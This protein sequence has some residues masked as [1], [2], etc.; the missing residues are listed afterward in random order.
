VE[1]KEEKRRRDKLPLMHWP[2]KR[3][4]IIAQLNRSF[5]YQKGGEKKRKRIMVPLAPKKM[6]NILLH[7]AINYCHY[8]EMR[9]REKKEKGERKRAKILLRIY[10]FAPRK[11]DLRGKKHRRLTRS[12]SIFSDRWRER[13]KSGRGNILAATIPL[14]R[15]GG[16][17][18][19]IVHL[20]YFAA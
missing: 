4:K 8:L 5:T 19:E 13:K 1:G 6:E 12:R 7:F 10:H 16:K 20:K 18:G 2:S 15:G 14:K 9:R 3:E 11:G 17:R